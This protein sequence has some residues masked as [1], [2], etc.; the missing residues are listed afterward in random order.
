M[1]TI[2]LTPRFSGVYEATQQPEP[3]QRFGTLATKPLKRFL[4]S[5]AVKTTQLKRGVNEISSLQWS[6]GRKP[7]DPTT[8]NREP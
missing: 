7:G 6:R 3:L 2:S 5:A 4:R 1:T 8:E